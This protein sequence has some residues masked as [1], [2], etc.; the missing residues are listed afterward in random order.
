MEEFREKIILDLYQ[1][2]N[3]VIISFLSNNIDGYIDYHLPNQI[4]KYLDD[5]S[6]MKNILDSQVPLM[7]NKSLNSITDETIKNIINHHTKEKMDE[8]VIQQQL[9]I[10]KLVNEQLIDIKHSLKKIEQENFYLKIGFLIGLLY[11]IIF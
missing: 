2:I 7:V 8:F 1:D 11:I 5:N 9:N 6:K 10:T 4:K 3:K